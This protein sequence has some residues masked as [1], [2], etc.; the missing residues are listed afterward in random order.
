MPAPIT[1][2]SFLA[3]SAVAAVSGCATVRTP[4]RA[5]RGPN[6]VLIMTDDQGYGDLACHGN[7]AIKTP[8][9][10]RL[11][12]ES[13]RFTQF[14]VMP[15][16]SPTRACLMTGRYNYRTGVVDTFQGRSMMHP[17]EVTVAELLRDHGYRTGI[18]GKWHL[19][20]NY[21]LRAMD[22]GFEQS[23]VHKGG[24]L[25]QPSD[26]PGSGYFD[27]ILQLNGV[28]T[29]Y[30]GY[31]TDIFTNA[32]IDFIAANQAQP[33]FCF[34]SMNAPHLPLEIAEDYV[35]PYRDA[36]LEEQLAKFFGMV[37]NLD[38]NVGRLMHHLDQLGIAENTL[39]IF[40]T[41]NGSQVGAAFYNAGMRG[42]KGTIY[43]GGIRVP[44][45][46]RWPAQLA[47]G[48]ELSA[49]A[50]HIDLLPTLLNA[51]GLPVPAAIALDGRNLLPLAQEPS[52]AWPDRYLFFQWHRGDEPEPFRDCA[53]LGPRYKLINGSDL[54]DLHADP[55]EQRDIAAEH[56]GI[57]RDMRAAYTQ[58]FQDVSSTR[59][60]E[61]PRIHLGS[62][63]ANPVTLTRQDWRG[64]ATWGDESVGHWE[65]HVVRPGRYRVT[66]DFPAQEQP[67]RLN[68]RIAGI[69]SSV[70]VAP[71]AKHATLQDLALGTGPTRLEAWLETPSGPR[72]ARYVHVNQLENPAARSEAAD[73]DGNFA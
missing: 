3:S 68:L 48:R 36:G 7:P 33:F 32:A 20:D 8:N 21:P 4:R 37:T 66:C 34:L 56:P 26:P 57:V 54:Y 53:V 52:P 16:C 1:R 39:L 31:C 30:Q 72:G 15:V 11:Y 73:I 27:P 29:Q 17:D 51:C 70:H 59:G 42:H 46:M 10:D 63:R 14:H 25:A 18:F 55:A 35:R 58:W 47:P 38:E 28:Q 9:L 64:A 44:F 19:G 2:R 12:A 40:M 6:V 24:G 22:Q 41:D 43:E 50:A 60:Y 67:A 65:V 62:P 69:E 23:L 5:P 13:T 45:F 61:P 71:G 49:T